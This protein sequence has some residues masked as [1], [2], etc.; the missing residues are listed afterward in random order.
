MVQQ[1]MWLAV[2][3]NINGAAMDLASSASNINGA[4]MDLASSASNVNGAALD[5]DSSAGNI[6]VQHWVWLAVPGI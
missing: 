2:P 5:V 6:Y 1:W 4:A 3:E